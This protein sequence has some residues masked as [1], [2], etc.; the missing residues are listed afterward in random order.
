MELQVERCRPKQGVFDTS[1]RAT[2]SSRPAKKPLARTSAISFADIG[3]LK[4]VIASLQEAA[5]IPLLHPEIFIRAGK[6]PIRGILLHGEPGQVRAFE[7]LARECQSHFIV[8][9]VLKLFAVY[10]VRVKSNFEIFFM[11]PAEMPLQFSS[12][13]N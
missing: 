4:S 6:E 12:S 1:T 2:A 8:F 5:V 9:Q 3:G 10:M 7:A 13:R 11:K